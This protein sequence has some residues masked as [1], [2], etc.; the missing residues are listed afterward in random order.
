MFF[1]GNIDKKYVII[2]IIISQKWIWGK[3]AQGAA[4]RL[5]KELNPATTYPPGALPPKYYQR[6]EA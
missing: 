4:M 5:Q 1:Y 6:A 3:K 2:D